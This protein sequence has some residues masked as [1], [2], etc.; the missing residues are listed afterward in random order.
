MSPVNTIAPVPAGSMLTSP[1]VSV[2][3]FP[4]ASMFKSPTLKVPVVSDPDTV[5]LPVVLTSAVFKVPT[6]VAF[7]STFTCPVPP[8]SNSKSAF[9]ALAMIVLSLSVIP[10]MAIA[11]VMVAA[12]IVGLVKTLLVNVCDPVSVV[13]VESIATVT[14]LPVPA[15]VIP[16]PPEN[17]RLSESKSMDKVVE[18]SQAKSRSLAVTCAST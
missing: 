16:V 13:T 8:P 5:V 6:T 2:V 9:E 12:L 4:D 15:V 17:C 10:L 1:F 18:S 7:A 3:I 11:P 14:V